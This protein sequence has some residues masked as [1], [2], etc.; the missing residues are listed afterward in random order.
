MGIVADD[1]TGA[2]DCAARF[3][4]PGAPVPVVLDDRFDGSA[5]VLA[6]DTDSRWVHVAEAEERVAKAAWLMQSSGRP[7]Y[8]KVDS[9]LRGH[10]VDIGHAA[11]RRLGRP[12]VLL[13]PGLPDERRRVVN[14][15]LVVDGERDRDILAMARAR[16]ANVRLIGQEVVR[17]GAGA[18]AAALRTARPPE[19]VCV[20]ADSE[21]AADLAAL[22]AAARLAAPDVLPVGSAGLAAGFA[23]A[24]R[25]GAPVAAPGT[26][27]LFVVGS[28]SS[29]AAEQVR[30]LRSAGVPAT[31]IHP[32]APVE[33]AAR[34]VLWHL[35]RAGVAVVRLLPAARGAAVDPIVA[36]GYATRLATV[37]RSAVDAGDVARLV[38]VGGDTARAV[39]VALEADGL[40]VLGSGPGNS[41]LGVVMGGHHAGMSIVT[42]AGA[43]GGSGSLMALARAGTEGVKT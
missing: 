15:W 37:A 20:V 13:A 38:L 16:F 39:L 36:H 41:C 12:T 7:P 18:I 34:E 33:V 14:G 25:A 32:A 21:T 10:P 1:L 2:A 42:R 26:V 17:R 31:T 40:L 28:R 6:V 23:C 5:T 4:A 24:P 8:I 11:A 35:K 9:L 27:T 30:R 19:T 43:F 3:A 22:A 29:A